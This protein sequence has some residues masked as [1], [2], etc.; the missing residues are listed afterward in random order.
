MQGIENSPALDAGSVLC[1]Q[2]RALVGR[3]ED[4]FGQVA[5]PM[6]AVRYCG[7]SALPENL[8]PDDRVFA[9]AARCQLLDCAAAA[10]PA[11]D[12]DAAVEG[13]DEDASDVDAD[14]V[15]EC[16]SSSGRSV[17]DRRPAKAPRLG[18]GQG[19]SWAGPAYALE[20]AAGRGRGGPHSATQC[21]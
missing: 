14:T 6:Y 19:D 8:L 17:D 15:T 5:Q 9:V 3:V 16:P 4:T 7:A 13:E 12:W 20:A 11:R 21:G 18:V 2:E 10:A 1:T